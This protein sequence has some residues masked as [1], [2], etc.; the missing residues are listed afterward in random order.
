M[1][2][3]VYF[4]T[5]R[6][7]YG[8][9]WSNGFNAGLHEFAFVH[10]IS[11]IVFHHIHIA[12]SIRHWTLPYVFFFLMSAGLGVMTFALNNTLKDSN[13]YMGLGNLLES[14]IFWL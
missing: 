3:Q 9:F 6:E 14:P 1:V 2:K 7:N 12:F 5:L 10:N 4:S 11:I 13:L 8:V